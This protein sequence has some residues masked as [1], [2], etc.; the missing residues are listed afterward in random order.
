MTAYLEVKE[1]TASISPSLWDRI[2]EIIEDSERGDAQKD[3]HKQ[4]S[5]LWEHS[6]NTAA[7]ALRICRAEG[8]DPKAPV[9]GAL[10]HDAGKFIHGAYHEDEQPE[11][12]TSAALAQK[13]LS[14]QCLDE[15]LI[16]ETVAG[17]L[18]L[19][20]QASPPN[21]VTDVIHDADFLAKAGHLGVA[22]FFQKNTLRGKNLQHALAQ[23]LSRELTYAGVLPENMRTRAGRRMAAKKAAVTERFFQGLLEELAEAGMERFRIME[24]P[25]PCPGD[26]Q[27]K[28]QIRMV[29]PEKCGACGGRIAPRF[30]QEEG[31][32]CTK[33]A[34]AIQCGECPHQYNIS[35]CLPEI[36]TS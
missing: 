16:R 30:S 11:E 29:I 4:D 8:F 18:A 24:K 5:F 19:Y 36:C 22:V 15:G 33:L 28:F 10:F 35:F 17:I 21:R 34:A 25:W 27:K 26:P 12:H 9:L 6:L 32:K 3:G 1:L 7:L 23:M 14:E 31:L 20:Q 2:R 13:A